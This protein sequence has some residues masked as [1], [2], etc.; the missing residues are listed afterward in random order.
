MRHQAYG[1]L[2]SRRAPPPVDRYQALP[3]ID[4]PLNRKCLSLS[5][6]RDRAVATGNKPRKFG[7]L[8]NA[9]SEIREQAEERRTGRYADKL[10]MD[11]CRV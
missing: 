3:S 1:Y 8:R 2:P 9:V 4:N 11:I 5:L 6:D 10:N 7:E